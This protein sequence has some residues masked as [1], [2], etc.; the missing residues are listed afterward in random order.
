MP[1]LPSPPLDTHERKPTTG[2]DA[3]ISGNRFRDAR[4][5]GNHR[6]NRA[7][8]TQI[9]ENETHMNT[10]QIL[11]LLLALSGALNMAFAAGI[12]A[13]YA[14]TSTA[15]AILIAAGAAATVMGTFFTAISAYH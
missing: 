8:G 5:G 2:P 4:L 6:L 11:T 7:E 15:Q 3:R 10:T 1:S 13:R 9:G 14:G 12:T